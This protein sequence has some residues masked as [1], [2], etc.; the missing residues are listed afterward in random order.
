MLIIYFF[1]RKSINSNRIAEV[2][3]QKGKIY[4]KIQIICSVFDKLNKNR[5][6]YLTTVCPGYVNVYSYTRDGK[7]VSGFADGQESG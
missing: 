2:V 7:E 4:V 6:T 5:S 1:T 3:P